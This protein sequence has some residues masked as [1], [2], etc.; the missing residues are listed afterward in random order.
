M[1]VAIIL[2]MENT[3]PIDADAMNDFDPDEKERLENWRALQIS[4]GLVPDELP[5]PA[6]EMTA[7]PAPRA[8]E[9]PAAR[10]SADDR[11]VEAVAVEMLRPTEPAESETLPLAA[12][13]EQEVEVGEAPEEVPEEPGEE[14]GAPGDKKRRR[15]RRRRRRG[16]GAAE[17]APA[18]ANGEPG[19]AGMPGAGAEPPLAEDEEEEMEGEEDEEEIEPIS[20]PDWNVP[21]WQ[22]LIDALYRPERHTR[23]VAKTIG[24]MT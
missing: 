12:G 5:V 9:P 16:E 6:A 21:T 18:E 22:E 8:P 3:N 15:R 19:A 11:I 1:T 4:L 2:L 10:K 7:P 13:A 14:P 23:P 20:I 17:G 24:A